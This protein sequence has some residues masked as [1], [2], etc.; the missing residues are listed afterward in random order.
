MKFLHFSLLVMGSLITTMTISQTPVNNKKNLS[1]TAT[2]SSPISDKAVQAKTVTPLQQHKANQRLAVSNRSGKELKNFTILTEPAEQKDI[3]N[4]PRNDVP[5]KATFRSTEIARA[6]NCE[7]VPVNYKSSQD[8]FSLF[9]P[10]RSF[11]E[12]IF[13]GAVY[14]FASLQNQLPVVYTKHISRNPMDLTIQI[15]DRAA[16]VN[17]PVVINTFDFGSLTTQYSNVMSN[18]PRSSPK[19]TEPSTDVILAESSSQLNMDLSTAGS[20]NM[21]AVLG[22]QM[23]EI[24][25]SI[26]IT[27]Q[28]STAQMDNVNS[29]TL[30]QKNS[31]VIRYRQVYYSAS[32]NYKTGNEM[33]VFPGVDKAQLEKDL[34]YV[35]SVDY[36]QVFYVVVTSVYQKDLLYNAVTNKLKEYPE[37]GLTES[38]IPLKGLGSNSIPTKGE[39]MRIFNDTQTNIQVYDYNGSLISLGT[40]IDEVL[41]NLKGKE[42]RRFNAINPGVP[43]NY[44]LNF[45][46]DHSPVFLNS[47]SSYA[48]ANCGKKM[49]NLEYT[50]SIKLVKIDAPKVIDVDDSED[51]IGELSVP[52][53]ETAGRILK[54]DVS[55]WSRTQPPLGLNYTND[56]KEENAYGVTNVYQNKFVEI[57]RVKQ[58][59]SDISSNE[60]LK[61]KFLVTGRLRDL[62]LVPFSYVC[63][64]CQDP[65]REIKLEKYIDQIEALQ[66]GESKSLTIDEKDF[67]IL[68]FYENN[69]FNSSHV[70]V[71]WSV[72]IRAT[73]DRNE[74]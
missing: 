35:K 34:V 14:Q 67:F 70:R 45:V 59:V 61:T 49:A 31:V 40:S 24:P 21:P 3:S 18:Y 53:F 26:G 11:R 15:F 38:V 29:N 47:S 32:V 37:L 55:F 23:P 9:F 33:D 71:F 16:A 5:V 6:R 63:N 68:H 66:P 10:A 58:M 56:N 46:T 50:V 52:K 20:I 54:E 41:T 17:P 48:M 36:G 13:P 43:I 74:N 39:G 1:V 64:G 8:E 60:I 42:Q 4:I 22:L 12:A 25:I 72:I 2:G 51:L 62:E 69:D 19:A 44:S 57:N 7:A 65:S 30:R 28:V 27:K 73:T